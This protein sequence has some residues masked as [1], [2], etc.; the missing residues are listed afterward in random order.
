MNF[1]AVIFDLYGTLLEIGPPPADA[2]EQWD[3][4]WQAMLGPHRRVTLPE[5]AAQC[6]EVITREHAAGRAAGVPHPEVLWPNIVGEVLP[7]LA[8]LT[9]GT[10]DEFL[11]QHSRLRQTLRL[12]PGAA[13]AL[14]HLNRSGVTL[15]LAS[16]CQPY[17]LRALDAALWSAGLTRNLFAP[18][19]CF[20][21]FEHGFSKPDP[22]VY[23]LLGAR[24]G[25]HGMSPSEVVMVGDRADHDIAPARA[26]GFQTW[27]LSA[28]VAQPPGGLW[29][30]FLKRVVSL[31]PVHP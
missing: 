11:F 3:R 22:H 19:L 28:S 26:Q 7:E 4:L 18:D 6:E 21:S 2:P 23:R 14:R 15:G 13:D 20:F 12:M 30:D 24:L 8:R 1:R 16:N 17:S 9:P 29:A 10:R 31:L 27:H 5:F 25:A